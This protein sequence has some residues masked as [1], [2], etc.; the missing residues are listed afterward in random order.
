MSKESKKQKRVHELFSALE[1]V[2]IE[3][4]A[5]RLF[6][7]N[8]EDPEQL[9]SLKVLKKL[10][11]K[12]WNLTPRINDNEVVVAKHTLG[13]RI[14]VP[15]VDI[16][17]SPTHNGN[18]E[19]WLGLNIAETTG[20]KLTRAEILAFTLDLMST[21]IEKRKGVESFER[22]LDSI[23]SLP[24]RVLNPEEFEIVFTPTPSND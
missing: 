16:F 10:Y 13:Y 15:N 1:W 18:W 4:A 20:K 19:S 21:Q 3:R 9:K 24:V 7:M 8:I 5:I 11:F 17:E 2:D 14:F 6:N 22:L 12:V 23:H